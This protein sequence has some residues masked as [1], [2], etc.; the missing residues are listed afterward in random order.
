M[1]TFDDAVSISNM[2]YYR[3]ALYNRRN[4][5]NCPIQSTFFVSHEYTDYTSVHELH[6]RGME[7]S[8]HSITHEA[9]TGYW[10]NANITLLERELADQRDLM[11][12]FANIPKEDIKGIRMPFL[13]LAGNNQY[14]MLQNNGF[15]YDLS[16][17]SRSF[18][19]PGMWPYTLNYRSIQDCT[20]A[21]PCPTNSYPGVWVIPML[22]WF[23]QED[24][25]CAMVDSCVNIPEDE[26]ELTNWMISEFQKQYNGNRAPFGFYVHAAWF[27]LSPVHFNAYKRFLDYLGSRDDVFISSPSKVIEWIKDPKP[28]TAMIPGEDEEA[29]CPKTYAPACNTRT[30]QLCKLGQA[31]RW[32]TS[33]V[34]QC[35]NSYPWINNPMGED[36]LRCP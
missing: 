3:E 30:C 7:V 5:D 21:P 2:P 1:L 34:S 4:P 16:W 19:Q 26:T 24:I 31:D 14:E 8:L 11:S 17:P 36:V 12:F 33:C 6:S 15:L 9:L 18:I 25:P 28:W 13:Q 20:T 10:M 35:P 22:M 23:D 29:E 27:N 32:M